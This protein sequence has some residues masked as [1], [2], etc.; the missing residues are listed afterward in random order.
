MSP[1]EI[2]SVLAA[3]DADRVAGHTR[4]L[5]CMALGGALGRISRDSSAFWHRD[6]QY[7]VGYVGQLPASPSGQDA[8][9]AAIWAGNGGRVIDP[10]SSGAYVN[11]TSTELPDWQTKYYGGHYGKLVPVKKTYD[12]DD[13]FRHPRSIGS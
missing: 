3:F 5:H 6:A 2:G 1:S 4:I 7:V 9:L 12:P 11:F 8:A 10:V 13:F